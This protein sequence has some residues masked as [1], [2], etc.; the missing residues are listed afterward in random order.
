LDPGPDPR[1]VRI[2]YLLR[3]VA[4]TRE[5]QQAIPAQLAELIDRKVPYSQ[6]AE[7]TGIPE[8]TA[9]AWVKRWRRQ[10]KRVSEQ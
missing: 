9:H 5:R 2:D 4:Q 10:Q 1:Q 7:E 6:I 8:S 3:R